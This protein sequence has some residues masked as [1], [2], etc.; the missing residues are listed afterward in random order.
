MDITI[1]KFSLTTRCAKKTF[2]D[3]YGLLW[4]LKGSAR[5]DPNVLD[6][7]IADDGD[8]FELRNS[9]TQALNTEPRCKFDDDS[10]FLATD[11]VIVSTGAETK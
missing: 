7:M 8:N 10:A 11:D 2:D 5:P 9:L 1:K 4:K 6:V 3:G